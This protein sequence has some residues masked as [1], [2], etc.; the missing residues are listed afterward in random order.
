MTSMKLL[1][2]LAEVARREMAYRS[3]NS[4][5]ALRHCTVV[6]VDDGIATGTTP[7]SR[8]GD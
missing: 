1:R 2:E 7:A 5:L 3:G 6:L 8:Q 4:L